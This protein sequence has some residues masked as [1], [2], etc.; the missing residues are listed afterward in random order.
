M[1]AT[2]AAGTAFALFLLAFALLIVTGFERGAA[3]AVVLGLAVLSLAIALI[4]ADRR[5]P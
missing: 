2:L 4:A 3:A 5:R 1:G